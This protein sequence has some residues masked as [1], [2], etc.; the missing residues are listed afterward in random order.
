MYKTLALDL[1]P[2]TAEITLTRAADGNPID[3]A[4]LAELLLAAQRISDDDSIHVVLVTSRGDAFSRGCARA[5]IGDA[6]A[7]RAIELMPQPVIAVIEGA[8]EGA[9]LALSMACDVRV[10]NDAATFAMPEVAAGAMP[11][12]GATQ[13]LPR[14]IGRA[15]A[16]Q[17]LLAGER[18]DAVTALSW[19]LVNTVTEPGDATAAAERM[20][21]SMCARG[22][23]AVR[24]AKEAVSRG[25]DMPLD[26]ALRYETD[27]TVILQTTSD[28]AEGVRAFLEKRLPR[29]EGR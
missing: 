10:A 8:A 26:E 18:I 5:P 15:R 20:A 23:L 2:P 14:L 19:G 24:Y 22:P 13:R 6:T 29:F 12:F 3:H 16:S 4:L 7:F 17:M 27:L 9:G 11:V 21:A 25:L 1:R 28:R